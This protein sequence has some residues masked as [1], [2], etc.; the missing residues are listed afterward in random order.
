MNTRVIAGLALTGAAVLASCG[1]DR[2]PV[3]SLPTEATF[4]KGPATNYC[5]FSTIT[6]SAKDYFALRNDPVYGLI[7]TMN[8]AYK[9][10]GVAAVATNSAGFDVLG[11]LGVA[12]DAGSSLVKGT[13]A[14]GSTFA[15][16]VLRCMTVTGYDPAAADYN[17]ALSLG[18]DGMLGS[19]SRLQADAVYSR[20]RDENLAPLFGAE[21]S[22]NNW[23]I[24]Y[25]P[26]TAVGAAISPSGKA[27]FFGWKTGDATGSISTST[28]TS[29][30]LSS[31]AFQMHS[32][33]T[34]LTFDTK[35]RVGVCTVEQQAART[36]HVHGNAAAIL[37]PGGALSFCSSTGSLSP[38]LGL[39]A[40][41]K[42]KV[43]SWFTPQPLF[44]APLAGGG[45]T[46]LVGGLS[47]FGA[48]NYVPSIVWNQ[49]P[50]TRT[51]LTT[52]PQF[53]PT[54]KLTVKTANGT[55]YVGLVVLNVVGNSGSFNIDG[56]EEY[57]DATGVVTFPDLFIDKAGGYTMTAVTGIGVSTPV[58][59]W[60]NGQ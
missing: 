47:E 40:F 53:T 56:E 1:Q 37:A 31:A 23:P 50:T 34:P 6:N 42:Q 30:D 8:A 33:P 25:D 7:A 45:G 13:P 2:D 32:L 11:R 5:S 28:T 49:E 48:V 20:G 18:P 41:A 52:D 35:I 46:G 3:A 43:A 4:A 39:F 10:G 60:I 17:F 57:T 26:L 29:E 44:A 51:T 59:F 54:V 19:R 36:V 9:E 15:N 55:P 27:L 16:A 14:Q 22:A 21:P 24:E 12:A 58:T 38:N